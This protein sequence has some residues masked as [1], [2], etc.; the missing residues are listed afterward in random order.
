MKHPSFWPMQSLACRSACNK[1]P[2]SSP[3]STLSK[4]A[5]RLS[6]RCRVCGCCCCSACSAAALV[7]AAAARPVSESTTTRPITVWRSMG[8]LKASSGSWWD[9]KLFALVAPAHATRDTAQLGLAGAGSTCFG[10]L[11]RRVAERQTQ[12]TCLVCLWA[13]G[14]QAAD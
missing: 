3:R 8:W 1:K 11:Q 10:Q 7:A 13:C 4:V 14:C 9:S 5:R 6:T 12:H 2:A